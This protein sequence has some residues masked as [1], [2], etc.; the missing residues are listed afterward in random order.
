MNGKY[1]NRF[2]GDPATCQL[3]SPAGG[4]R[5]ETFIPWTL[6]KRGVKKQVITPL[7]APQEFRKEA[8]RERQAREA[9]QDTALIRALGL[10]HHWQKLLDSGKFATI[11][12]IANAEGLDV[13]QVRR[14]MRLALLAPEVV[15]WL[16]RSPDVVLEQVMRRRWSDNW[17]EQVQIRTF[18]KSCV[19]EDET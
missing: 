4:V 18:Q 12:E 19:P 15:E 1:Q 13:T 5:M 7:D 17:N 9:L 11:A 3:A 14:V 8:S 10:A 2:K 16:V 6:V